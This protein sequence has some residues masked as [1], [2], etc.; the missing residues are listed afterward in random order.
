MRR[1]DFAAAWEASDR[2]LAART[3]GERCWHLPRH[4]Q[5]VWDGRPLR[6]QRVLVRCYHGLGDTLQFARCLPRLDTL[7][8]ETIVWVQP[9]LIDLLATLP[10]RERRRLLPLHDGTPEVDYDVDLE[11]M[12]LAHALRLSPE[13]LADGVPYFDVP[14][15]PRPSERLCVGVVA[16]TGDWDDRRNVPSEL[17]RP[18]A[19]HP[20]VAAFNL[21]LDPPLPGLVDLSTPDV[22]LLAKRVRALDLVITPDTM[23][24]HLAGAL[25]VPVWTLLPA[26]ADWRW[27]QPDRTDS[28]W[29]PTMRLFRQPRPGDWRSVIDDVLECLWRLSEARPGPVRR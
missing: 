3:P 19:E 13:S 4:E 9:S 21:Q 20:R 28:P 24:A 29:Y 25:A 18:L 12:E 27:L 22:L 8:R 7:A 26:E 11:I 1:G 2:I 5:W 16:A 17:L 15:A 10:G 6:D 23:L 14:R